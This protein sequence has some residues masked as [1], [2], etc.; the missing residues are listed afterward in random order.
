MAEAILPTNPCCT[1]RPG[2]AW[3]R[4][5]DRVESRQRKLETG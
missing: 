1:N 4:S 2:F 3:A 5:R